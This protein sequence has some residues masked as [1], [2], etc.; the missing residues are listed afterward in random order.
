M[1]IGSLTKNIIYKKDKPA[2]TVALKTE[3]TKE[4]RIVM[5]KGQLMKEHKA[6][7]PIVIEIFEGTIDFGVSG[8]K[9]LLKKG[10]LIALDKNIPHDLTCIEDCI[11]R[12]SISTLDTADR[13]KKLV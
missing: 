1:K 7:F 8:K 13:V 5:K 3:T 12:L 10:D 11:V 9:H 6:P 4:I 2:I